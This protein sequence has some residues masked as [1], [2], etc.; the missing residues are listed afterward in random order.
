MSLHVDDS[1]KKKKLT[2]IH[3]RK[4]KD[5]VY[6]KLHSYPILVMH[7]LLIKRLVSPIALHGISVMRTP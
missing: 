1:M 6:R 3:L 7:S 5:C 2:V 4:K